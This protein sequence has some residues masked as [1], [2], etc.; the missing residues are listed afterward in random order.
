MSPSLIGG[1]NVPVFKPTVGARLFDLFAS[2]RGEQVKIHRTPEIR[3]GF[4][5]VRGVHKPLGNIKSL[6]LPCC[7][8]KTP[9]FVWLKASFVHTN[10]GKNGF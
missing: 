1:D 9:A 6:L 5:G 8:A 7:S 2:M 10:S 3:N 4:Y